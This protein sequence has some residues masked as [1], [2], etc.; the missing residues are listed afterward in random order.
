MFSDARRIVLASMP[1]DLSADQKHYIYERTYDEKLPEVFS[2]KNNYR[3]RYEAILSANLV[4]S[5]R[6][7]FGAHCKTIFVAV[8][9]LILCP[10]ET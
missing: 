10:T 5:G 7:Y 2:L 9:K 3:L 4:V 6:R 1:K 8:S